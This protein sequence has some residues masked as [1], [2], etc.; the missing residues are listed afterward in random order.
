MVDYDAFGANANALLAYACAADAAVG[1]SMLAQFFTDGRW[2]ADPVA[3]YRSLGRLAQLHG[4]FR[5]PRV[6]ALREGLISELVNGGVCREAHET[7]PLLFGAGGAEVGIRVGKEGAAVVSGWL[8]SKASPGDASLAADVLD[9]AYQRT[10]V[11]LT[12]A[13]A[14]LAR[15]LLQNGNSELRSR[16]RAGL[17]VRLTTA[18]DSSREDPALVATVLRYITMSEE[19]I[20]TIEAFTRHAQAFA[21]AIENLLAR[22]DDTPLVLTLASKLGEDFVVPVL[23]PIGEWPRFHRLQSAFLGALASGDWPDDL[24]SE[25]WGAV[26]WI[27][28]PHA[29]LVFTTPHATDVALGALRKYFKYPARRFSG[30]PRIPW[31]LRTEASA[32][33]VSPQNHAAWALQIV[34]E[35]IRLNTVGGGFS[36]HAIAGIVESIDVD[37]RLTDLVASALLS[38]LPDAEHLA[39]KVLEDGTTVGHV[40]AALAALTPCDPAVTPSIRRIEPA[41][42]LAAFTQ[43]VRYL[44]SEPIFGIDLTRMLQQVVRVELDSLTH[45]DKVL[46]VGDTLKVDGRSV[47]DFVS[48]TAF[49]EDESLALLVVYLAHELAHCEQ[50]IGTKAFVTKLR[51]TGAETT[52]LHMDLCADHF[53]AV[54]AAQTMPDW[55]VVR[56]KDLQGRSLVAFEVD[57]YNIAAARARKA[58]RLVSLRLDYLIRATPGALQGLLDARNYAFADF[59]PGGGSMLIMH[60]GPPMTM[61]AIS[62]LEAADATVLAGA[63]DKGLDRNR[64]D[65]IDRLLANRLSASMSTKS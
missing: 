8:A 56:L 13:V 51:S 26:L 40:R 3:W 2:R 34:G 11:E 21:G 20:S 17:L 5:D 50:G 35:F 18:L 24:A 25:A 48:K 64:L 39:A 38:A 29:K 43:F 45:D 47:E 65:R 28:F 4:L 49:N 15:W 57:A 27:E 6:G 54:A 53:A 30:G 16:R 10:D 61:S 23:D 32:R 60:S 52:L 63:A 14:P 41:K 31:R 55:D 62:K 37:G 9:A 7:V 58:Q 44:R 36:E 22:H 12:E 59:G 19:N 42:I 33:A 46:R 1:L